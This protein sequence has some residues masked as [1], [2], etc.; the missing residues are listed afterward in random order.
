MTRVVGFGLLASAFAPMVALLAV[1]RFDALGRASWVILAVCGGAVVLLAAVL[2]S[3]A[4]IQA[5]TIDCQSVR[6]ADERVLA[7]TSSYVVPLVVALF[8]ESDTPTL[9]ATSA[10][11]ALMA[12]I[13]V[14]A[15]LYHLNPTLALAGYRLYE[16]TATNGTVTMVLTKEWQHLRQQGPLVCRYVGDDVAIHRK[17]RP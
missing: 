6:R 15:G 17:E 11:V 2:R 5:R 8:G 14:R 1:V 10:L 3:V 4:G 12:T 13:Y 9:V 7:F 16:V